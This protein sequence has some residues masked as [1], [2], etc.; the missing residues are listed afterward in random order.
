[1]WKTH[2]D[3]MTQGSTL[4]TTLTSTKLSGT[5]KMSSTTEDIRLWSQIVEYIRIS[6]ATDYIIT[7]AQLSC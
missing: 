4:Y 3:K 2:Y 6:F 1:M 7:A 5:R